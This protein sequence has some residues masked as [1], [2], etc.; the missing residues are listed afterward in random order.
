V[1][2]ESQTQFGDIPWP[3]KGSAGVFLDSAQPVADGVRV[4]IKYRS[5]RAHRCIVVLPHP[6]RFK[7]HLP[8]LVGKIAKTVQRAPTV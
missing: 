7:K 8:L 5:R 6:K 3:L 2:F 1:D 4:A